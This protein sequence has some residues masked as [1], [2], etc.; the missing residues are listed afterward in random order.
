VPGRKFNRQFGRGERGRLRRGRRADGARAAHRGR[1]YAVPG[2]LAPVASAPGTDEPQPAFARHPSP[3]R[4]GT[5]SRK[6]RTREPL[7]TCP[8]GYGLTGTV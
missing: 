1:L 6:A 7:L 4:A 8:R 2:R 3:V 5:V